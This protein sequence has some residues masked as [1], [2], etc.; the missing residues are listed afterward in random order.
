MV[1]FI[2]FTLRNVGSVVGPVK[3][4]GIPITDA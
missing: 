1:D 3:S 4:A 2:D